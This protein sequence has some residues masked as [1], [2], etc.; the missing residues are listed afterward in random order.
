MSPQFREDSRVLVLTGGHERLAVAA[1]NYILRGTTPHFAVNY[2]QALGAN[3]PVLADA[4]L[5]S[6]EADYARLQALFG[7][8]SIGGL[9]FTVYVE[10]GTFGAYHA[11]CAA[12]GLTCAAFTGND[13]DLIKFLV[14]VEASEVLMADQQRG[15]NCG[16]SAG[17][18][19]SRVI[20]AEF[21]P[22]ELTPPGVNGSFK[23]GNFWLNGGRP[24]FVDNTDPT[25]RNKVSIGCGALFINW[26]R[27]QLGFSLNQIVQAGGTTLE[28]T[29]QSLTKRTDGFSRFSS[30]ITYH[31]PLGTTA[32]LGDDNPFPL[33]TRIYFQGTDDKLWRV[34]P[35]GSGG[36]N[37]GGY[38][39]KSTPVVFGAHLYF[40]GTD[41]ALWQINLDGTGGIHVGGG[42]KTSASPFV[43]D[44]IYFRGTDDKLWRV[45]LDGS[46]GVNLGGYKTKSTPHAFGGFVFFQGTDD[47]L[48]RINLDG[49]GGVN[50]GG[51]K[52]SSPPFVTTSHVYFRGTDDRLLR[53]NLDGSGGLHLGGYKTKST[54][55]VTASFV[56]FQGTDDKLWRINLDGSGGTNLAGYKTNSSPVADGTFIYFQGTD[57]KFWRLNLDGSHGTHLGGFDNASTPTLELN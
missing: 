5:G 41:D 28:Q 43:S 8:I 10:V 6:C 50:L 1:P 49:S 17:E 35:D 24:N 32:S 3:G 9:P 25:D 23:T 55:F 19:L 26:L 7:N 15:W 20:G 48:W 12:T 47:K 52:T 33:A 40:Q 21:Y 45:N 2:D 42:Y 54:P 11:S 44:H 22:G 46:G 56:Y 39:T 29:Y 36:T 31:F 30:L 53:I 37:L 14:A 4:V 38:K 51:N 18:A 34:N 13:S 27:F 57:N 16:A